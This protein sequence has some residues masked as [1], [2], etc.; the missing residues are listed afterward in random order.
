MHIPFFHLYVV[1]IFLENHLSYIQLGMEQ[2]SHPEANGGLICS[3]W[4][5]P[6]RTDSLRS[7][8][9]TCTR[10]RTLVLNVIKKS[11]TTKI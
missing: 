3:W 9:D 8:E 6:F 7:S 2:P 5:D 4:F 11:K 10:L 1:R